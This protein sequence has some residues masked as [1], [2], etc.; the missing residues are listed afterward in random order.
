MTPRL[1]R[2]L[3][4]LFSN[5]RHVVDLATAGHDAIELLAANAGF[6]AVILDV[7]LPGMDGFAAE[8]IACELAGATG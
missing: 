8:V 6:D 1:G 4:R 3:S 5:D 7:G 2:L